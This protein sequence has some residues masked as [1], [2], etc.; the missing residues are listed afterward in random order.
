MSSQQKGETIYY[1]NQAYTNQL[2]YYLRGDIRISMKWNRKKV[3]STLSIDIQNV[4]NRKNVYDHFYD[5]K[6]NSI[7]TYYQTGLIPVLNYK[8][9]F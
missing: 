7:K 8:L 2:P 5:V 6:S 1:Q 9:E 3:T 4:S